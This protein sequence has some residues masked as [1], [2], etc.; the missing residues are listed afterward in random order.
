MKTL[1]EKKSQSFEVKLLNM[2][3]KKYNQFFKSSAFQYWKTFNGYQ[4]GVLFYDFSEY[5]HRFTLGTFDFSVQ[6]E[7]MLTNKDYRV[8]MTVSKDITIH[9]FE[10]MALKFYNCFKHIS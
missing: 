1:T 4:V 2:G 7:V 10:K 3:Y 8:D 6:Y 9:K 5:K